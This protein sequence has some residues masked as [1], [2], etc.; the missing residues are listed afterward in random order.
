MKTCRRCREIKDE[1]EFYPARKGIARLASAAAYLYA[2]QHPEAA[3]V[4]A[5][6]RFLAPNMPALPI[7]PAMPLHTAL[8]HISTTHTTDSR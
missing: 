4:R 2:E 1:S 8:A 5:E 7:R 6:L 3:D